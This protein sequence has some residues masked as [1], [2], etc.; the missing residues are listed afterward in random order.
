MRALL[1]IT[2]LSVATGC[3]Q[4]PAPDGIA[5]GSDREI[6]PVP[7][8]KR[9][10]AAQREGAQQQPAPAPK[11]G[12]P[13]PWE[14]GKF[15]LVRLRYS[16]KDWDK[17]FGAGGD[18]NLLLELKKQ[19]PQAQVGEKDRS[20][21]YEDLALVSA[22]NPLPLIFVGGVAPFTPDDTQRKRLREY[23]MDKRGM[24][25][26]DNLSGPAFHASFVKEMNQITGVPATAVPRDDRIHPGLGFQ[27]PPLIVANGGTQVLG[28]KV[29]GRWVAYYHPG[30][31]SNGWRDDHGDV[32]KAVWEKCYTL[33]IG[34][35]KYA[36]AEHLGWSYSQRLSGSVV[37][38][39]IALLALGR[40]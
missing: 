14:P 26:C 34:I 19:D 33:G 10:E 27:P 22:K 16:A 4:Q 23:L 36:S 13:L 40:I 32:K 1:V 9:A 5:G 12:E 35:L 7:V 17:N 24:V 37:R 15:E 28:W 2:W 11:Q 20:I 38:P 29:N 18:R 8:P 3:G 21:G 39:A 31:L 6:A 25:L 30:A